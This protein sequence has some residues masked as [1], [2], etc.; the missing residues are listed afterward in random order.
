[1][2]QAHAGGALQI[3]VELAEISRAWNPPMGLDHVALTAFIELPGQPGGAREMPGQQA[4]LPG[5]LR[6]HRRLRLHGWSNA[7]FSHEGASATDEG[8]PLRPAADV[9]VDA[10]RRTLRLTLA[11]EALGGLDSLSGARVYLSTWD[12]DGGFRA[13]APQPQAWA[14]GGGPADGPKVMD[15]T[16]VLTLR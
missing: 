16:P 7:L 1:M 9:Q 6:W 5:D 13:L 8:R 4:S 2:R 3:E 14:F 11:A 15:E 12:Y 10:E